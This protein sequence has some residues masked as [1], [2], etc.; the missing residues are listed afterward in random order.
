MRRV[1]AQFGIPHSVLWRLRYRPPADML[2]SVY[3]RLQ[4]THEAMR[5]KQMRAFEHERGVTETKSR[6][7]QALVRAADALAGETD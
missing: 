2:A 4:A 6:A 3:L 5:A 1:E 7:A